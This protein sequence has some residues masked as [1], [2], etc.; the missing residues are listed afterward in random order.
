MPDAEMP[1]IDLWCDK[2]KH[3][4]FYIGDDLTEAMHYLVD[5]NWSIA[6]IK[7]RPGELNMLCPSCKPT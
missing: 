4:T 6:K 3:S 7:D 1:R 2:C 5:E